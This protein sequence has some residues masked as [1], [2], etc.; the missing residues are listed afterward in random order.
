[1]ARC[2]CGCGATLG[3]YSAHCSCG[4][5]RLDHRYRCSKCGAMGYG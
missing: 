3:K 1:M 2:N 4:F 5:M